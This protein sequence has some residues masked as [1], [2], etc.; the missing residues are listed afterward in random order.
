MNPE[1]KGVLRSEIT[2]VGNPQFQKI[3]SRNIRATPIEVNEV[4]VGSITILL[5]I[6]S[7]MTR[8]AFIPFDSGNGPIMSMEMVCHGCGGI[9][10][11]WR[12]AAHLCQSDLFCWQRMQPLTYSV[13]SLFIRGHQNC[14]LTSSCVFSI[15]GCPSSGPS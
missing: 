15:L 12:G 6:R 3:R 1:M 7:T 9:S 14:L 2:F 5:L 13:I 4:V 10:C 8:R 11:T